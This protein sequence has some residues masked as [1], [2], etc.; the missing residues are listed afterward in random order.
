MKESLEIPTATSFR[1]L[2]VD[3]LDRRRRQ[4][5]EA[6]KAR[7]ARHEGVVHA[8]DRLR[9]RDRGRA[10]T[11]TMGH[12]FAEVDGKPQRIVHEYANLGLAVDVQ[13]KDGSRTLIVPVIKGADSMDFAALPRGLRGA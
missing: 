9:D 10:T 2:E 13:R 12:S 6:L 4:L 8:P 1:T 7:A 3:M 11:P 5:N